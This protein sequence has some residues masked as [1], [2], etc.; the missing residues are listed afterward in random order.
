MCRPGYCVLPIRKTPAPDE[1]AVPYARSSIGPWRAGLEDDRMRFGD[2]AT[3]CPFQKI[4][5][6]L[7]DFI[8]C[9][10]ASPINHFQLLPKLSVGALGRVP[11]HT[12]FKLSQDKLI[13]TGMFINDRPRYIPTAEGCI[14][15]HGGGKG[16]IA[17][18]G[19]RDEGLFA[20]LCVSACVR[21]CECTCLLHSRPRSVHLHAQK[22]PDF[23]SVFRFTPML[24]FLQA[25][26]AEQCC[27]PDV[28]SAV[29]VSCLVS[30]ISH[31]IF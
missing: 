21:A 5:A 25:L 28:P 14:V 9:C 17:R 16:T 1:L 30:S 18:E 24:A 15:T 22:R 20:P 12:S 7:V 4:E 19:E 2:A 26:L 23:A 27:R 13:T 10:A 3:Q 8:T 31:G 29:F 11:E 6:H